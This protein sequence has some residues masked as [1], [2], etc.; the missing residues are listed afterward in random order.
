MIKHRDRYKNEYWSESH[1]LL[2]DTVGDEYDHGKTSENTLSIADVWP[3]DIDNFMRVGE[4]QIHACRCRVHDWKYEQ[5]DDLRVAN[6][7]QIGVV[8]KTLVFFKAPTMLAVYYLV[9]ISILIFLPHS[10]QRIKCLLVDDQV[11]LDFRLLSGLLLLA[12]VWSRIGEG[13]YR[14][15]HDRICRFLNY[16]LKLILVI[17]GLASAGFIL[18][19]YELLI[20][21]NVL[22]QRMERK[23]VIIDH[24]D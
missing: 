7:L 15:V 13:S 22:L 8:F 24:S 2:K 11:L 1:P 9:H 17:S 20:Q 5:V 12:L 14:T 16:G 4:F 19:L 23:I 10:L 21:K 3:F 6:N 18:F